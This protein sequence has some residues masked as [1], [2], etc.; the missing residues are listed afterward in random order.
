MVADTT[1]WISAAPTTKS[2]ILVVHLA[3]WIDASGVAQATIDAI[4]HE[5]EMTPFIEFDE[6][7][8]VDFRARRP[9]VEIRD[10][11]TTVLRWEHITLSSGVDQ[12][13]RDFLLLTGPEPDMRWHEFVDRVGELATQF[14]VS[15]MAH[16]GAYP[17]ATPHTRP[18][19]LAI[20]SPSAD[21]VEALSF[22]RSSIDVPAGVAAALEVEMHRRGIPAMGI[23]AEV[24]HYIAQVPFP[25]SSVA[26][27]DG[28]NEATGLVI[29]APGLRASVLTT[30]R[31]L[32]QMVEGNEEYE[33]MVSQLEQIYEA[34][35]I[36]SGP[37]LAAPTIKMTSGEDLA[38]E[39]ER[40]LRDLE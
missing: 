25:A 13:G 28:L 31:K 20:S 26:L 8:F 10:G 12:T 21:V 34:T 15:R 14:G 30:R 9:V 29:D 23:W 16:L 38:E 40:Y 17:F 19:R 32:D 18:P 1:R 22:A 7:T 33:Q 5:T 3:G 11:V 36:R 2:P 37:G 35:D 27:L 24:P 6:D 39:L 4:Q